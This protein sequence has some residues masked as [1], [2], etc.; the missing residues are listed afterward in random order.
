MKSHD[1]LCAITPFVAVDTNDD[2]LRHS[3]H[4]ISHSD[5][6]S[7]QN[8]FPLSNSGNRYLELPEAVA[9]IFAS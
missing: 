6:S 9:R 7:R 8:T 4:T 3:K 1:N 2:I 5:K